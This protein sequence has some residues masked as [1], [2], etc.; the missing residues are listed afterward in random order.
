MIRYA[1]TCAAGHDFESWFRSAADFDALRAGQQVTCSLCGTT[2]V[3][4]A[5]MAPKLSRTKAPLR[6]PQTD[7]EREIAS[8]KSTLEAQSDYVGLS[9]AQEARKM[10]AGETPQRMI[11]GEANLKEAKALIE[12]GVPVLP[13]PFLNPQKTN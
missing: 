5:L 2:E 4:K 6:S 10:H 8:F 12:E 1:L 3:Q 11:H 13:L 9:F 7:L